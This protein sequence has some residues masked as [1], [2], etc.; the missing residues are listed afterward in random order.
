[1]RFIFVTLDFKKGR[2]ILSVVMTEKL[3]VSSKDSQYLFHD[4]LVH[5]CLVPKE[6]FPVK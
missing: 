1:M 2:R 3:G 4:V 5:G 6:P